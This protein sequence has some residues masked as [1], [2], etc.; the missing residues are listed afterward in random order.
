MQEKMSLRLNYLDSLRSLPKTKIY[1]PREVSEGLR[2]NEIVRRTRAE[3]KGTFIKYEHRTRQLVF[4]GSLEK[5][6]KAMILMYE[7]LERMDIRFNGLVK[8]LNWV[9]LNIFSVLRLWKAAQN[10]ESSTSTEEE[11]DHEFNEFARKQNAE[12]KKANKDLWKRVDELQKEKTSI[13]KENAELKR[14]IDLS[15]S[16]P[17]SGNTLIPSSLMFQY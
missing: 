11:K 17:L 7:K 9:A 14:K 3:C 13:A 6:Q 1:V 15:P 2:F 10:L 8:N 16:L 5:K 12:L 4:G